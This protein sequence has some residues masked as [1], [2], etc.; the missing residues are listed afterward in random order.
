M[1]IPVAL[2]SL[3]LPLALA[4]CGDGSARQKKAEAQP[5]A[6]VVDVVRFAPRAPERSF[7]GVIRP[8]VESDIGF[9]V[10]GKVAARLVQQGDRVK[11]G[12]SLF[13]L[14][15]TD[16]HL[17][18]EQAAAELS[19]A[20]TS[21]ASSAAQDKRSQDLRH[22]GWV[23]QANLDQQLA[24]TA[25]TRGRLERAERAMA[26][27]ENQ[28]GYAQILADADGIVT[29]TLAEPGQV[30][31]AGTPVLRIARAGEVDAVVAI[32]EVLAERVRA[33]QAHVTLWSQPGKRYEA[34]LREFAASADAATRTFQARFAVT[35]PDTALAI[36]MTATVSVREP[37][38][39]T[40][41]RLPVSA[42]YADGRGP[43]LFVV[44]P[45]DGSLTLRPVT[46]AGYEGGQVLVSGGIGDGARVVSFGVQ[47]LDASQKVRIIETRG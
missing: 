13:R 26:L 41:A 42:L 39:A 33:G 35:A 5:R 1:R 20:R 16:L 31:A 19:A 8:R 10:S 11:A 30:V 22:A 38:G 45:A 4:A 17:Q 6:V 32:P 34:V 36:G 27:A 43:S 15:P 29:A 37:D 44:D 28:A 40:I 23:S 14:D 9:R 2:F 25:D 12:Q 47:K 24:R 3:L 46:I 21:L 7:V 18:R